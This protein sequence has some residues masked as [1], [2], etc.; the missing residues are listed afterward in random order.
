MQWTTNYRLRA[1][2]KPHFV[3]DSRPSSAQEFDFLLQDPTWPKMVSCL[4]VESGMWSDF[5]FQITSCQ[6]KSLWNAID[7][8]KGTQ[9][10]EVLPIRKISKHFSHLEWFRGAKHFSAEAFLP[11]WKQEIIIGIL[12]RK[13]WWM[14]EQFAAQFN[15]FRHIEY[16]PCTLKLF[17][18]KSI[19]S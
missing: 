13:I 4:V 11:V 9:K 14:R 7:I 3:C 1:R 5:F 2:A 6:V 12:I 18:L 10:M 16:A 15:K 17:L 19:F 8:R